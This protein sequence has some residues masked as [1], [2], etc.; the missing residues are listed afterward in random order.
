VTICGPKLLLSLRADRTGCDFSSTPQSARRPI[1]FLLANLREP[2]RIVVPAPILAVRAAWL[3]S[4]SSVCRSAC[5][6]CLLRFLASAVAQ[7]PGQRFWS[8]RVAEILF[9]SLVLLAAAGSLKP[10]CFNL[11]AAIFDSPLS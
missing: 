3:Q 8:V 2:V 5:C 7:S 9:S 11:P 1:V 6:H 10:S 4:R